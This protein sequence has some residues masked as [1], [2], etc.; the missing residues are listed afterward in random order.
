MWHPLSRVAESRRFDKNTAADFVM[1]AEDREEQYGLDVVVGHES[2]VN[3]WHVDKLVEDFHKWQ[4][5]Q[6]SISREQTLA[7]I[8]ANTH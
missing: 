3:T 4:N 7:E 2:Y 6:A 5:D 1:F 8:N